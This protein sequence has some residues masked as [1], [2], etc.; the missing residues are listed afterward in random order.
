MATETGA[1]AEAQ[2]DGVYPRVNGASLGAHVDRL[3]SLVGRFPD[4]RYQGLRDGNTSVPFL[5]SDQLKIELTGELEEEALPSHMPP[6]MVV[7]IIG[8]V[9]GPGRLMVRS[10][11]RSLSLLERKVHATQCDK[12]LVLTYTGLRRTTPLDRHGFGRVR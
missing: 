2:P 6:D 4:G 1:P 3:V 8:L 11:I 7:E 9:Q 12:S 10:V 5:C